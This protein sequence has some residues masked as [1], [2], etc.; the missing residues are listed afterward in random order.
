ML[1]HTKKILISS[2]YTHGLPLLVCV[3]VCLAKKKQNQVRVVGK[4]AWLGL[5]RLLTG[6]FGCA[7]FVCLLF[8]PVRTAAKLRGFCGVEERLGGV[9]GGVAGGWWVYGA[10]GEF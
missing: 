4:G 8:G 10:E 6:Q 3:C 2:T 1:N 7:S 5:D 9:V